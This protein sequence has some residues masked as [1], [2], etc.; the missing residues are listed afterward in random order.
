MDVAV[1]EEDEAI[2]RVFNR[3]SVVPDG[4]RRGHETTKLQTAM[5]MFGTVIDARSSME[6]HHDWKLFASSYDLIIIF[7]VLRP[8]LLHNDTPVNY[9]EMSFISIEIIRKIA[10]KVKK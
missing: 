2:W 7:R 4:N 8:M 10:E 1:I 5:P 6:I 9:R 3:L